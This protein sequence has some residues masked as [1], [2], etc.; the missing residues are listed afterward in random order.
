MRPHA[1]ADMPPRIA[2]GMLDV[3]AEIT[4][5]RGY[6]TDTFPALEF[7]AY[8]P[9]IQLGIQACLHAHGRSFEEIHLGLGDCY[10]STRAD[11][12]IEWKYAKAAAQASWLRIEQASEGV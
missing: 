11:S 1:P 6:Y 10:E 2:R 5:W 4:Y 8:E 12:A 3:D 9:A 7:A